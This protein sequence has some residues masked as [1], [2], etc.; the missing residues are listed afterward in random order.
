MDGKDHTK[1]GKAEFV[2]IY[3]IY[4]LSICPSGVIHVTVYAF[5]PYARGKDMKLPINF[6]NEIHGDDPER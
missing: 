4:K 5:I 3:R 6:K 2:C 1:P